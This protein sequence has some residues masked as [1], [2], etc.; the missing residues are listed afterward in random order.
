MADQESKDFSEDIAEQ[1]FAEQNGEAENNGENSSVAENN[2]ESQ[3]D[4][5][6]FVGGL[7]WETTDKELREH[8]SA[9]G[10]IESINVKT[11]PN[12]GRSRGFAFIV[13]AKAESLDK[14]MAAGDHVINNKKVDPKKAKAR[15][16]KIF[17]GGLSTEL[18]DDDIKNF[19]SQFGTIVEVEMPFDKTKN[20]RKGFCFITFESEQVVNE[21]LKTSKQTINGKEAVVSVKAG[22]ARAVM[23]AVTAAATAREDTAA[24]MMDTA[25][26]IITVVVGTEVTAAATTTVDTEVQATVASKGVVRVRGTNPINKGNL[27]IYDRNAIRI[28]TA[29]I[30]SR[31]FRLQS[32]YY[33]SSNHSIQYTSTSASIKKNR[34][35]IA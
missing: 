16:G 2:Q 12:T 35:R 23:A 9:Y 6:L 22:G 33:N 17:V 19:F 34:T 32:Q 1:N 7:S 31:G 20:Q 30:A 14:I 29:G 5:K 3:E 21:L 11:D 28:V 10:D 18:S 25:D 8:F 13:F 15:H 26:T 24:V 27:L 4:R